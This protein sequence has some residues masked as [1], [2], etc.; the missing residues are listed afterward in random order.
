M[1]GSEGGEMGSPFKLTLQLMISILSPNS[2]QISRCSKNTNLPIDL[3][4]GSAFRRTQ[5]L[6][7]KSPVSKS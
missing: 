6:P 2:D 1:T 7:K 4:V 3:S 5:W